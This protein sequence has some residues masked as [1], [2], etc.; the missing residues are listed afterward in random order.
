MASTFR[1]LLR[2]AVAV[3]GV[4]SG[5]DTFGSWYAHSRA[6]FDGQQ[7][8]PAAYCLL[9][10]MATWLTSWS[11]V[12]GG[13]FAPCL[14]IGGALRN[15]IAALTSYPHAPTLIALGL[16]GFLAAATQVP[17]TDFI[18]VME[19]VDGHAMVLSLMACAL[20]ANAVPKLLGQ[21]LYGALSQLQ[22]TRLP[23]V[24]SQV[25]ISMIIASN[26]VHRSRRVS[27]T[28][29]S[30]DAHERASQTNCWP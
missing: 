4:V 9:K 27:K 17:L 10:F 26:Y 14:S 19:M 15:D 24:Y 16:A 28:S 5:G 25:T 23:A 18:I 22:L 13:I 3:I 29:A 7:T 8:E 30:G 1:S 12:P 20:I 2:L 6:M 21:P 11:G